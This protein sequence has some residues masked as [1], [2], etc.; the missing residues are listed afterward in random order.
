MGVGAAALILSVDIWR[1]DSRQNDSQ[2]NDFFT[3]LLSLAHYLNCSSS[4]RSFVYHYTELSLCGLIYKHVTIVNDNSSV[5]N[6]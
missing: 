3:L 6:K 5:I 2:L 1:P 4:C